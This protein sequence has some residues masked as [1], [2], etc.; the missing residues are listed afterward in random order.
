MLKRIEPMIEEDISAKP[1]LQGIRD[2][3]CKIPWVRTTT[4]E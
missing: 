1:N 3:N 2:K 4:D